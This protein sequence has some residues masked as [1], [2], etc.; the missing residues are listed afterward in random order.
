MA[1]INLN[2]VDL[3]SDQVIVL[4]QQKQ[5]RTR[6]FVKMMTGKGESW[7]ID[8]LNS[9][10]M[11]RLNARFNPVIWDEIDHSRRAVRKERYGVAIPIDEN[12]IENKLSDPSG[13]YAELIVNA[14]HRQFDRIVAAAALANVYVGRY[15]ETTVTAATD[16]VVTVDGTG[17]IG[18]DD[19]LTIN[20]NYCDSAIALEEEVNPVLMMTGEEEKAL[21]QIQQLTS[22]D[23]SRQFALEKG[24]LQMA[25]GIDLL[26][27]AGNVPDPILTSSGGIRQCIVLAK[28]A[29][30]MF[31]G[32]ELEI[33]VTPVDNYH[34]TSQV[35]AVMTLGAT[36]I[37]GVRVQKVNTTDA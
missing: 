12:D 37:E 9:I 17:G 18:Y 28:E 35:T 32:H 10:E 14:A 20:M 26:K 19:L 34:Q 11:R 21:L 25:A 2:Y 6:P 3:F 16:G 15:G 33:K 22:G 36:R 29:I 27:F 1:T 8:T 13:Q 7:Y 4:A 24:R 23:Y 5:A 31:M 30:G